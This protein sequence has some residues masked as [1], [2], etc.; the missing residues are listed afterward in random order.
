MKVAIMGYGVV[1]SGVAEV[2]GKN[3][4]VI[5][6]NSGVSLEL[7]HIL[8]IREFPNDPFAACMTKDFNAIL[9]DSETGIV[10]ETMG[11]LEPAFTFVSACLKNG[12]HVVTSNKELV[13]KKGDEL[14]ALAKENNVNFLFEA[15]VG[16]GIPIIR[17]L[18]RCLAANRIS[19]IA[20]I[21][22]GTTNFILTKMIMEDMDFADALALAQKNGYAEKDP[23]A[24]VEGI[25]ACRKICILASL[26][27]GSH[28]YPDGVPTKG[29]SAVTLAD[30]K[31]AAAAG[32]V[33]KLIA[34]AKQLKNGK[35][36]LS[37]SPALVKQDSMLAG[38]NAVFNACLV[39]GDAVGDVLMYGQGAGKLAT[40]SA[41]V[42]DVID[43][44]VNSKT[45]IRLGWSG[46]KDGVLEA[47]ENVPAVLFA[48]VKGADKAAIEKALPGAATLNGENGETLVVT[49]EAPQGELSAALSSLGASI[50]SV[51]PVLDY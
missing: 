28:V 19:E 33:I 48:R 43:C 17:P 11:G 34:R 20:G 45:R 14:L 31:A 49:G 50:L 22:N 16:G 6:Q 21:L 5:R 9:N 36:A 25:D 4:D 2:I 1:G 27:F 7:S 44:A 35:L 26:V 24:D 40:A 41:V 32:C 23:T 39:R 29:I 42:G 8:D 37:V 10:V 30:V 46:A 38:V 12:K 15:S 18:F 47:P 13:A 51:Y 3:A